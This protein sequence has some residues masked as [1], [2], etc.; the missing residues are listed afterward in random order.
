MGREVLEEGVPEEDLPEKGVPGCAPDR[1]VR[2]RVGRSAA[3]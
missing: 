2:G 3:A 1:S